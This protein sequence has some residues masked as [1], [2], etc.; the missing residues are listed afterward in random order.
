VG[1]IKRFGDVLESYISDSDFFS[2]KKTGSYRS[3]GDPDLDAA[4]NELNDFLGKKNYSSSSANNKYTSDSARASSVPP[5]AKA[6]APLN[7][8][9]L[10]DFA[11]LG[12]TPQMD[13]AA[14]K[15]AYKKLLQKNHPDKN[16]GSAEQLRA[17]TEKTAAINT[18][19]DR[20]EKW[21]KEH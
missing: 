13:F 11:A 5:K 2:G 6:P 1:I 9:L 7:P 8:E 10:R 21:F 14:C 12:L 20:I 17:A 19:W 15:D 16:T 18:S 4:Y 3:G